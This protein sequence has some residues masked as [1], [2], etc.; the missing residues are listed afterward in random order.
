MCI[1]AFRMREAH[2]HDACLFSMLYCRFRS[3]RRQRLRVVRAA[4]LSAAPSTAPS[5]RGACDSARAKISFI[6]WMK[7]TDI[8]IVRVNR[9]PSL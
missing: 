9:A 5:R 7:Y 1:Y 3:Q 8:K 6:N 2:A 4:A